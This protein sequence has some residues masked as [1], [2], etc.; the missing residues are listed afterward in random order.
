MF[1]VILGAP[2]SGKGTRSEILKDKL[3]IAHISTGTMIR[4]NKSVYE[5]YKDKIDNGHLISDDIINEMLEGR[6]RQDDIQNGCILDGYPRT[7]E[8]AY[9]LDKVLERVGKKIDKV[10][11]LDAD[12]DTIQSRILSRVVCPKCLKIYNK[13]YAEENNNKCLECGSELVIRKDDNSDTLKNRIDVY[14]K[15]I[16]K[17]K[18]Y[19]QNKGLLEIIDALEEPH[20]ILER[21]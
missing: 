15:N 2:G 9:N 10:F 7:I 11:L 3:K 21:V 5:K 8:Q 20:K 4:E 13:K 18:E 17:I 12:I 16:D 14:Y 1:F 19:Y 6:F